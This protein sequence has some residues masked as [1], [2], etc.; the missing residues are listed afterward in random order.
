MGLVKRILFLTVRIFFRFFF[1]F[2]GKPKLNANLEKTLKLYKNNDFFEVFTYIRAWDAPFEILEKRLPRRGLIYDLGC[3]D[4]LFSNFLAL[5]SPQR[6]IVGLEL[7][8]NRV[9]EAGKGIRNANFRK[10]DITKVK[11]KKAD[12]VVLVHVLHHLRSYKE[13]ERMLAGIRKILKSDGKLIVVEI[14]ERPFAKYIFT[15]LTDAITVPI[16][17]ENK[18]FSMDFYYRKAIE[19]E[20]LLNKT[21]F[22]VSTEPIHKG[23][24]FSHV[25][26]ECSLK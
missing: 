10:A 22:E 19:W 11:L 3:G 24:P 14:A 23:K 16:L 26:F 8:K 20:T 12:A 6:K 15:W 17:F 21:G 7:D 18:F 9:K 1:F 4:G 25:L 5:S 2:F 13:Q